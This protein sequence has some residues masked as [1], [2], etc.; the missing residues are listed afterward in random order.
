MRG[1]TPEGL[2]Q[3]RSQDQ[4]QQSQEPPSAESV[5]GETRAR[6]NTR[7]VD[8]LVTHH[9]DGVHTLHDAFTRVAKKFGGHKCVGQRVYDGKW[10]GYQWLTYDQIAK[11]AA[12]FG[13]GLMNLTGMS[14]GELLGIWGP[15]SAEWVIATQAAYSQGL[16][17]VPICANL[18]E[19]SVATIL[20]QAKIKT[21]VCAKE[22]IESLSS[23]L[24]KCKKLQTI[25]IAPS[26]RGRS[27][28]QSMELQETDHSSHDL[29]D[30]EVHLFHDVEAEGGSSSEASVDAS[31]L[32]TIL[33]TS[34]SS[35]SATPK[36]CMLTHSNLIAA[37]AGLMAS[38]YGISSKD[39][40]FSFLPVGYSLEHLMV[41]TALACGAAVAFSSGEED[42]F[43]ADVSQA[44]PTVLSAAPWVYDRMYHRILQKVYGKKPIF[45]WFFTKGY[46][47]KQKK[48]EHSQK[49]G[50]T[51]WNS[52]VF[53]N[54]KATMGGNIRLIVSSGGPLRAPTHQFLKICFCCDVVNAYSLAE[55]GGLVAMSEPRDTAAGHVG[56]PS[57][58]IELK[59]IDVDELGFKS[60]SE[61]PSG[62][63]A[64]RGPAVA[65]SYYNDSGAADE[66]FD[67]EGWLR[68]G[69]IAQWRENGTLSLIDREENIFA[70]S[71]GDF[72]A[73]ERLESIY[74]RSQFISQIYVHGQEDEPCLVAV[75]NVNGS[76]LTSFANNRSVRNQFNN[77]ND[78]SALCEDKHI[79]NLILSDFR[80]I[81][82]ENELKSCDVVR[83]VYLDNGSWSPED[84]SVTPLHKL[85]RAKL[86]KKYRKQTTDL[87]TELKQAAK[88]AMG[89]GG[90]S[91][92]GVSKVKKN[93]KK[94]ESSDSD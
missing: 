46:D 22:C 30:R 90:P 14:Q 94:K 79:R 71:T 84:G 13:S 21:L 27:F 92:G 20:S 59:L 11:R 12:K 52:V 49:D 77:P 24:K 29:G 87:Y 9:F 19:D 80:K 34:G 33:Y 73:V 72:V 57:P 28:S 47:T 31:S 38:L 63:V 18:D 5:S 62:H 69:D 64:I 86:E 74:S 4:K 55:A 50:S 78:A 16:V 10:K 56:P 88:E 17:T 82:N 44:H 53:R 61:L 48:L 54:F 26:L 40:F 83:A 66:A 68:T 93:K 7:A 91:D 1:D 32:A 85:R 37:Q 36:G 2:K 51:L 35:A 67:D 15:G 75:V 45:R 60:S 89:K 42:N 39:V 81:A 43:A 76:V 6:R 58:A 3:L 25:I 41:T 8:D 65:Q 23:I 70:L